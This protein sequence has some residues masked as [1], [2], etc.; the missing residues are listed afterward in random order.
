MP[1]DFGFQG[2]SDAVAS[3][4]QP[5]LLYSD[6]IHQI[7]SERLRPGKHTLQTVIE[8]DLNPIMNI[9][10][11]GLFRV[12]GVQFIA[13]FDTTFSST[14]VPTSSYVQW[15]PKGY[16]AGLRNDKRTAWRPHNLLL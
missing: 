4:V 5:L 3:S 12:V 11:V 1:S 6:E 13:L 15:S 9:D 8:F 14:L 2:T 10:C 7:L 16:R